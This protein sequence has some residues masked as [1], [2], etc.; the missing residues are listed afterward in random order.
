MEL[1]QITVK[2]EPRGLEMDIDRERF[3]LSLKTW[4]LR[5]GLTQRQVGERWGC[6]RYTIIRA[7]SGKQTSWMQAYKLFA[8]LAEELRSE[9]TK[10]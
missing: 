7:E 2:A 6:S 1:E 8:H 10:S 3:A 4:R 9:N 5:Q